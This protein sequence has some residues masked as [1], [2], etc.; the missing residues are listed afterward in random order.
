MATII[1][2]GLQA[3]GSL[4]DDAVGMVRGSTGQS[5]HGGQ[6]V[7]EDAVAPGIMAQTVGTVEKVAGTAGFIAFPLQIAGMLGSGLS[8]LGGERGVIGAAG[9]ALQKPS[10]VTLSHMGLGKTGTAL[11]DASMLQGVFDATLLVGNGTAAYGI[12]SSFSQKVEG[13]KQMYADLTGKDARKVST[14]SLLTGKVPPIVAETRSGL[15][16]E[17]GLRGL[18][19]LAAL[20][21]GFHGMAKYGSIPIFKGFIA[22]QLASAGIGLLTTEL[23]ISNIYKGFSDAYRRK[24]PITLDGYATLVCAASGELRKRDETGRKFAKAI[25]EKYYF[26][27]NAA[28]ATILKDAQSGK[29]MGYVK[30]IIEANKAHQPAVATAHMHEGE[31]V[32]RLKKH[33]P[34]RQPKPKGGDGTHAS[35]FNPDKPADTSL[36]RGLS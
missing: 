14:F 28:P 2:K 4:A 12:A 22:P 7:I 31:H 26:H 35:R 11:G 8:W 34:D 18:I 10:K 6:Q 1:D 17:H 15:I 20:G 25:A 13:L 33:N 19:E 21:I 36:V 16:S 24:E 23:P 27:G 3:A 5:L 30:D 29:L 9:N 32:K